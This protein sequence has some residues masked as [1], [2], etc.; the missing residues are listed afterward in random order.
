ML[1]LHNLFI[2]SWIKEG[3]IESFITNVS[4]TDLSA[5]KV[6]ELVDQLL[7]TSK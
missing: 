5:E 3:Q 7:N 2:K 1:I 6:I 4:S